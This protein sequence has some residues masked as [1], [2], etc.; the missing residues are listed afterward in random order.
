MLT[1]A[2][3][4]MLGHEGILFADTPVHLTHTALIGEMEDKDMSP[5]GKQPYRFLAFSLENNV[6]VGVLA[7]IFTR[8]DLIHKA[9]VGSNLH[10]AL[11]LSGSMPKA[12][13]VEIQ[14]PP[15]CVKWS[16]NLSLEESMREFTN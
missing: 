6:T 2:M 3:H 14:T 13:V 15:Y 4:S 8:M 1:I 9:L 11:H 16:F 7:D 12:S 5:I 10:T